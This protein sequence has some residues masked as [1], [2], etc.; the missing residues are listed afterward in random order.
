M[1]LLSRGVQAVEF[2]VE[3]VQQRMDFQRHHLLDNLVALVPCSSDIRSYSNHLKKCHR[4]PLETLQGGYYIYG[5][6]N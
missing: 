5:L 1:V 6:M 3:V 4:T 2:M